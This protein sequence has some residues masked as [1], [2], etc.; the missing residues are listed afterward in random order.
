MSLFHS[1]WL[2]ALWTDL[3]NL[4]NIVHK[5]VSH[6]F[7]KGLKEIEATKTNSKCLSPRLVGYEASWTSRA[8]SGESGALW[9]KQNTGLYTRP[10]NREGLTSAT[11]PQRNHRYL[12]GLDIELLG[13]GWNF[14]IRKKVLNTC[15][16]KGRTI[17]YCA[18]VQC[19]NTLGAWQQ[20]GLGKVL[21]PEIKKVM[22]FVEDRPQ[23]Q[24][25]LGNWSPP[26]L[27]SGLGNPVPMN[28]VLPGKEG[29]ILWEYWG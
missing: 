1:T 28:S 9:T 3:V 15:L 24:Q 20:E 5:G 6:D 13:T 25:G 18:G 29:Y 14:V 12:T 21:L 4:K 23:V 16:P 11:V 8:T 17:W 7:I 10:H 26:R 22:C 19:R 2:N 27:E